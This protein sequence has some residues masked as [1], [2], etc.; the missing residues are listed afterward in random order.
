MWSDPEHNNFG[1]CDCC[2]RLRRLSQCWTTTGLETWACA[3]C[4]HMDEEEDDNVD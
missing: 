4:R 1:S 2:G 3:E